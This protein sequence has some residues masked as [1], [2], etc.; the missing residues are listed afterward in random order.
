MSYET[1]LTDL[2][3]GVMTAT[4]NRPDKLNAFTAGMMSDLLDVCTLHLKLVRLEL[5]FDVQ[6]TLIK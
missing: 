5:V 4:R 2:A 1:L 3:A 6:L